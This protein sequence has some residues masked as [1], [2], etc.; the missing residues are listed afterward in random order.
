[1]KYLK[2][3]KHFTYSFVARKLGES[4]LFLSMSL[5]LF[6]VSNNRKVSPTENSVARFLAM[7]FLAE[8]PGESFTNA[9]SC[10]TSFF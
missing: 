6:T 7:S 9:T 4:S 5:H 3:I 8:G 10:S 2:N 1:M